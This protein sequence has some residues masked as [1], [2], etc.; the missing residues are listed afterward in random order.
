MN[1]TFSFCLER[2]STSPEKIS[3]TKHIVLQLVTLFKHHKIALM[4][5]HYCIDWKC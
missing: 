2:A 3:C 1:M 4:L 5:I